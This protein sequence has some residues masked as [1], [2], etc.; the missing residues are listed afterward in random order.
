M[1]A[2]VVKKIAEIK[3]MKPEEIETLVEKNAR[4]LF[5]LS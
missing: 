5:G 3:G 2:E 4:R 1:V